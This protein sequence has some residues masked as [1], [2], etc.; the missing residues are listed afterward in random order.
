MSEKTKML[1]LFN[2]NAIRWSKRGGKLWGLF[3][4]YWIR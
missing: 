4:T 3:T 2:S 1:L